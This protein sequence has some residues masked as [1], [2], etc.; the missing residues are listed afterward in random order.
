M[1]F[2]RDRGST[3][4]FDLIAVV[5]F[6]VLR[7]E[8][9]LIISLSSPQ[10]TVNSTLIGGTVIHIVCFLTYA[11][12]VLLFSRLLSL[13]RSRRS[14]LSARA[15]PSTDHR[16]LF[17]AFLVFAKVILSRCCAPICQNNKLLAHLMRTPHIKQTI[18]NDCSTRTASSSSNVDEVKKLIQISN[19][20]G[21]NVN[22]Q[23]KKN[24]LLKWEFLTINW[25]PEQAANEKFQDF[26]I[27]FFSARF[28]RFCVFHSAPPVHLT[29]IVFSSFQ[30]FLCVH[31]RAL[32]TEHWTWE[33]GNLIMTRGSAARSLL[34][35]SQ[36]KRI[37]IQSVCSR[38]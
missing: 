16:H 32:N 9:S 36:R 6:K 27:Q 5:A 25:T 17:G 3:P 20:P 7:N 29:R 21:G 38:R 37:H 34:R 24:L 12:F 14:V 33:A 8:L 31:L 19:H 1:E 22:G 30:V 26:Y 4:S 13:S 18:H 10:C 23:L 15:R 11:K 28:C 2:K 35:S